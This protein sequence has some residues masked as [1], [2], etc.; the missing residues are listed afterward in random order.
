MNMASQAPDMKH[1]TIGPS[2]ALEISAS[3]TSSAGDFDFLLGH[4]NIQNKKLQSRL[5][6]C[7]E[8]L[9]FSATQE[10]HKIL[11]GT[12]NI[13]YFRT[14]FDGRPF[15]GMSLRLFNPVT[16]LWSIYWADSNSGVLDIPVIGSFENNTGHFFTRDTFQQKEIITAFRWD[17]TVKDKPVWSQAFSADLG[18][19]W[20]WN[21]YMF[22]T[23][24]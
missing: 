7:N 20:E 10:F 9:A 15:E 18:K 12:G 2:G 19:T 24:P 11:N 14:T 16:R 21:W 23:R 13:D 6:H 22:A 4:W 3:P 17:A 8:W 5:S 1:V